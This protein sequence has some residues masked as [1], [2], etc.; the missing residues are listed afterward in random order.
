MTENTAT[1][2]TQSF[3][4][5][6]CV[7]TIG[8]AGTAFSWGYI[9][10]FFMI[11]CTDAVGISASHVATLLLI[12]RLFDGFTDSTFGIFVDRTKNMLGRYRPWVL[13]FAVPVAISTSLLFWVN[14]EWTYAGKLIWIY[15]MYFLYL[16][17]FTFFSVPMDSMASVITEKANER[18]SL[19][20]WK[21]AAGI[22]GAM[23]MTYIATSYLDNHGTTV[24]TGYFN[25]TIIFG[26][27]SIPL[28]LLIGVFCKEKIIPKREK[29]Y[30]FSV[31]NII[32]G[33][34]GNKPFLIACGGHFLNGLICYGRVSI[35][36]YYFKYVAQDIG[37]F[38][39]F[40]LL[41]RVPQIIGAYAAQHVIKFFKSIGR[42]ITVTYILYGATLCVNY[43]VKPS[44]SLLLFWILTSL[45]SFLFGV[46]F[47]LTYIIIPDI[48]DERE[49]KLKIR[50]DGAISATLAFSN[51]VGMAIGTSGM[52]FLLTVLNYSPNMAQSANVVIGINV[53]MFVFPGVFAVLI[54]LLFTGY[55]LN[56]KIIP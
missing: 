38:A 5:Q 36:I 39:T 23:I 40:I 11:Y 17:M 32:K 42:A 48:V 41:M 54:G 55:K 56:S 35:F 53:L 16:L 4:F 3:S 24:I 8:N 25:L 34:L 18:R 46:T 30:S 19:I 47:S 6:K 26:C 52:G 9:T 20:A 2:F 13:R 49:E 51:K 37:L 44:D 28:F 15:V 31:S 43:M 10:T 21:S 22:A 29:Q 27:I 1:K 14:P 45:S 7:Y 12:S 33:N 50:N